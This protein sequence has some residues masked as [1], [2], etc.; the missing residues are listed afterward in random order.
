M[1]EVD[2]SRERH[3]LRHEDSEQLRPWQDSSDGS[4]EMYPQIVESSRAQSALLENLAGPLAAQQR[5]F[6]VTKPLFEDNFARRATVLQ[7][8]RGH[9]AALEQHPLDVD[10]RGQVQPWN[11]AD[12]YRSASL[13]RRPDNFQTES[14]QDDRSITD[15]GI[16]YQG[17][18]RDLYDKPMAPFSGDAG[19]LPSADS[20]E[21]Q[22][23]LES[24]PFNRTGII[25]RLVPSLNSSQ[26]ALGTPQLHDSIGE[27]ESDPALLLPQASSRA[28]NS[29]GE[30]N[31]RRPRQP[32]PQQVVVGTNEPLLL[33]KVLDESGKTWESIDSPA[34]AELFSIEVARLSK[35]KCR[36]HFLRLLRSERDTS[37]HCIQ[38]DVIKYRKG[39]CGLRS[40]QQACDQCVRAKRPC[41]VLAHVDGQKSICWLSSP[42]SGDEWGMKSFWIP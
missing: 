23:E 42:V 40:L 41:A 31:V 6:E 38:C 35:K 27:D 22:N 16:L 17:S 9:I 36:P 13:M 4:R 39:E 19:V 29:V 34:V 5:W 33:S 11:E 10:A 14:Y 30:A 26:R 15:R 1:D 28:P 32:P 7:R 3:G 20:M 18:L 25:S 8:A 24:S 12:Q 2:T 21:S 37:E